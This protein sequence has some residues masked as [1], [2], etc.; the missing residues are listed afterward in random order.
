MVYFLEIYILYCHDPLKLNNLIKACFINLNIIFYFN[1]SLNICKYHNTTNINS[2]IIN[3]KV[4]L[5]HP[6]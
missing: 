4:N 2:I 6:E 1:F 3:K 5:N